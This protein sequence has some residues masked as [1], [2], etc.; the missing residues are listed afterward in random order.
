M[1]QSASAGD[2]K[3]R[4]WTSIRTACTLGKMSTKQPE[5]SESWAATLAQFLSHQTQVRAIRLEPDEG[6]AKFA[7]VGSVDE[8][9]LRAALEEVLKCIALDRVGEVVQPEGFR[10]ERDSSG[11]VLARETCFTSPKLWIWRDANWLQ[12]RETEEYEDWRPLAILAAVCGVFGLSGVLVSHFVDAPGWLVPL[13]FGIALIAG[14][15]DAATDALD[16]L[17]HFRL[18]IHF[19]MLLVAAGATLIGHPQ[20]GILLLF[21]FSAAGAMEAFA[22]ER[23]RTAVGALMNNAPK[24]AS[25]ILPDGAER[26]IPTDRI[27]PGTRLRIRP[28]DQFPV[29][30]TVE[31]GTTS[32]DESTLTGESVPVDK[33]PGDA[34]FAG[35]LNLWGSVAVVATRSPGESTLQRI[36]RMVETARRLKAPSERFTDRFGTR[37]TMGV[38]V[39]CSCMF[40][41][42]WLGFGMAPFS[43]VGKT[44]SALYRAMVLLVVLSPCALVISIPSAILASI[45]AGARRGI[46]FR[47]GA[48]VE[49]LAGIDV[50]CLDKTGTVTTGE[51][52]VE[53]VESYP[54]GREREILRTAVAVEKHSQHPLA[55]AIVAHG[56]LECIDDAQATNFRSITGAG[57]SAE[58]DGSRVLLGRRELL[59]QGPLADWAKSLSETAPHLSE[60]WVIREGDVGRILLADQVR[61][62]AAETIR[63]F[64][65]RGV[66][67]IMLT[68]DRRS[69]AEAVAQDI[70]IAE[71]RA[72]LKP[73]D[74]V[75]VVRSLGAE[76]RRV[77]MVGDGVN[78]A[79]S[80][81]AAFVSAGMGL[82]GS[83]A[84]LEESEIVLMHDRIENFAEAHAL[85]LRTKRVIR[86]NLIF[87]LGTV[88]LM[89]LSTLFFN[90]PLTL[91]V[92]AHEGSTVLVCLNSL[93][94]LR[95]G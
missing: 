22:L 30:A 88:G 94:L 2:R 38:L 49:K 24:E 50:L 56:K 23:T 26:T 7:T 58:V 32:V 90:V 29:D 21:L 63:K 68:G 33:A 59:E 20:E 76:G 75:A 53:S 72:G 4:V 61:N 67:T 82:R 28:G 8:I 15:W 25:E 5:Q 27:V 55:R 45:A 47:S 36:R 44:D 52:R 66:H 39:L 85:S 84:A 95:R 93:R 81:A 14:A 77:A 71:V 34:V 91:G 65:E 62:E 10:L 73:S 87:A 92:L 80:L 70:G 46:L 48:A 11:W 17:R 60:V 35:T 16:D 3:L 41:V 19:L 78:D 57:A 43:E 54:P 69:A 51:L 40:L 89:A 6:R 9:Q 1:I 79:P 83:D 37:Y 12:Q 31:E 18:D 74:K 86:Q 42:W 13:L 64:A